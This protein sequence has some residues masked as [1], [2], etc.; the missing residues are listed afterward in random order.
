M[1]GEAAAVAKFDNLQFLSDT[2]PR[3]MTY[4]QIKEKKVTTD[5]SNGPAGVIEDGEATDGDAV[6]A[7]NTN[8][9]RSIASMMAQQ[10]HSHTHMNGA[11]NGPS[12]PNTQRQSHSMAN[13]P[14]VDRTVLS[15]QNGHAHPVEV[16]GDVEMQG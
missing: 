4:K 6:G 7:A 16:D 13:S 12:T 3:T 10:H 15:Q 5:T 1:H 14:I 8:G 11:S 9:Q 2:V